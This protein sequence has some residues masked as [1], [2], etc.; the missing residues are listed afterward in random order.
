MDALKLINAEFPLDFGGETYQVKKANLEKVIL[1]QTRFNDLTEAKDPAYE[2]KMA[3]YCLY[4]VL[5]DVKKDVTEEWVSQNVP[6]DITMIDVIEQFGF[7][8]QQKVALLRAII[9]RNSLGTNE[10]GE[11][12][13]T[14][15][16]QS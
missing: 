10:K 2:S 1:F 7:M 5:R 4:L 9:K 15:S 16:T 11:P 13:G 6:G 12:V 8:N 14:S 3:G